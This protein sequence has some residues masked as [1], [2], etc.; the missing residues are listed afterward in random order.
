MITS[1]CAQQLYLH[2]M[3]GPK[4][5]WPTVLWVIIRDFGKPIARDTDKRGKAIM[6][7][8]VKPK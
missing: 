3:R 6:S 8:G 2:A 1:A 4:P 5:Y 7:A